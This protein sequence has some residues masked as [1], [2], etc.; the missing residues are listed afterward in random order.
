ML[1]PPDHPPAEDPGEPACFGDLNL[2]Q[3]VHA[4]TAS[5]ADYHLDGFFHTPLTTV[6]AVMLSTKVVTTFWGRFKKR[7]E[8]QRHSSR[9]PHLDSPARPP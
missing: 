9:H 3:I 5:R 2:D 6:A 1:Y 7:S 4:V 8:P